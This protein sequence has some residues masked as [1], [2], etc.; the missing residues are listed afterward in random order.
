MQRPCLLLLAAASQPLAGCF[1][2]LP[3]T[4]LTTHPNCL[5]D[6]QGFLPTVLEDVPDMAVKF[7]VYEMMR[8]VHS[9]LNDGRPA[10]VVEDLI[11]GGVAGAAAA[12]ATTPLDVLKTVM[13]CSASS[14]PTIVTAAAGIMREGKGLAPFFRGVGP[15]A[16]SNGLNSAIFFCFFEAIRQV[17]TVREAAGWWLGKGGSSWVQVGERGSWL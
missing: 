12:A 7:A 13:M 16:L 10:N 5:L 9:R 8:G 2:N 17:S 11:M 4:R 15:R 1:A 6:V 3:T 14:R